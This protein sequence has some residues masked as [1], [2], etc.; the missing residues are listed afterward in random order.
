MSCDTIVPSIL[1]PVL[2]EDLT[3]VGRDNDGGYLVSERSILN[4]ELL[5]SFGVNDDWS[6][7]K[8]FT[9]RKKCPVIAYDASVNRRYFR[10]KLLKSLKR[11]FNPSLILGNYKIYKDYMN[12]FSKSNK[13][14]DK[15]VG[16]PFNNRF[17][18]FD[19]IVNTIKQNNIFFKIDIEGWEYR[20][21]DDMKKISDRIVGAV[22]EF[23]DCDLHLN[24]IE[25][26]INEIG[27]DIVHIHA[28]NCAPVCNKSKIPLVLEITFA[29]KTK[30]S[31]KILTT[32]PHKLDMANDKHNQ[33]IVIMFKD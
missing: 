11:V 13:H 5:I 27:L 7:E 29:K 12:F 26:F 17:V 21:L 4:T 3:R 24:R 14:I 15:F 2:C 6:F 19:S 30:N 10:K 33:D 31:D 25:K 23:H 18:S 1:K 8:C 28:N 22:I 20:I 32:L 9:L 16:I